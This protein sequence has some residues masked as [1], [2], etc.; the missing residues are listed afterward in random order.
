MLHCRHFRKRLFRNTFQTTILNMFIYTESYPPDL[1][2]LK[3]LKFWKISK[4]YR[5]VY[6]RFSKLIA[7]SV[8][9]V[10]CARFFAVGSAIFSSNI[11]IHLYINLNAQMLHTSD[12]TQLAPLNQSIEASRHIL[13]TSVAP[14]HWTSGGRVGGGRARRCAES[15]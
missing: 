4:R 6:E 12:S 1:P 5:D 13:A 10:A 8:S 11:Y 3:M 2:F 7:F 15:N 14:R 9:A